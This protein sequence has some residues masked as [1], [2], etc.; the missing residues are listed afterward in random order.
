MIYFKNKNYLF[1]ET[2]PPFTKEI[3]RRLSGVADDQICHCLSFGSIQSIVCHCLNG[4]LTHELHRLW[5]VLSNNANNDT[6]YAVIEKIGDAY[7]SRRP[8]AYII[9]QANNLLVFLNSARGNLRKGDPEWKQRIQDNYDPQNWYYFDGEV[10]TSSSHG[11]GKN[12]CVFYPP[13]SGRQGFYIQDPDGR[14][15]QLFR[16]RRELSFYSVSGYG[17]LSVLQGQCTVNGSALNII[18]SSDNEFPIPPETGH[19]S[20]PVYCRCDGGWMLLD[21]PSPFELT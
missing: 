18:F 1:N 10:V 14:G 16:L 3:K 9:E 11:F 5:A 21:E 8:P 19:I 7:F 13:V 2:S 6:V 20:E 12:I 15:T 17:S 4:R